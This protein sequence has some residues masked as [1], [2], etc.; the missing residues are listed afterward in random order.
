MIN[1]QKIYDDILDGMTLGDTDNSQSMLVI[2][3]EEGRVYE[4]EVG[5]FGRGGP[6][7]VGNVIS[8]I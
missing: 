8:R 2:V 4:M 6:R 3:D 5:I 7:D 1:I